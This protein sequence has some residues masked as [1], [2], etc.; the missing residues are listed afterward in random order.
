MTLRQLQVHHYL[1]IFVG[2]SVQLQGKS[3][4]IL[5]KSMLIL[6]PIDLVLD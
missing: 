6:V 3:Y 1:S 5:G 4:L 2:F